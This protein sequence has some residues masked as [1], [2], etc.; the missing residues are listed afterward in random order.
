VLD[1]KPAS[2]AYSVDT[3]L[4]EM[5]DPCQIQCT[6]EVSADASRPGTYERMWKCKRQGQMS[7]PW[8]TFSASTQMEL[9]KAWQAFEDGGEDEVRLATLKVTEWTLDINLAHLSAREVRLLPQEW[10]IKEGDI[11]RMA[12][13]FAAAREFQQEKPMTRWNESCDNFFSV[14]LL[15]V[16]LSLSSY[17][18][19][20]PCQLSVSSFDRSQV[21]NRRA[22]YAWAPIAGKDSIEDMYWLMQELTDLHYEQHR[23]RVRNC[24]YF[25]K[26]HEVDNVATSTQSEWLK[27][28]RI[29][30][31]RWSA[32]R[33]KNRREIDSDRLSVSE[34]QSQRFLRRQRQELE[35]AQLEQAQRIASTKF[36]RLGR[37][38]WATLFGTSRRVHLFGFWM[39]ISLAFTMFCS[40]RWFAVEKSCR[41]IR[42]HER[43]GRVSKWEVW[44]G[45]YWLV[46]LCSVPLVLLVRRVARSPR[47]PRYCGGPAREPRPAHTLQPTDPKDFQELVRRGLG[48]HE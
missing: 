43:M 9:N 12:R 24:C 42:D 25:G 13:V 21:Q 8:Q 10:L 3:Y 11:E 18:W 37:Y 46:S 44:L 20:N 34:R 33:S 48:G 35:S 7:G 47:C 38:L 41:D 36:R 31:Q 32:A 23:L 27:E 28:M 5:T 16:A 39:Y 2:D 4:V 6:R 26:I 14:S 45:V 17:L 22:M 19:Y 29:E 1:I 15:S 40:I 30:Q